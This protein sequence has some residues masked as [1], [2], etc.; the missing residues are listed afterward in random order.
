M[1]TKTIAILTKQEDSP[2]ELLKVLAG[3]KLQLLVVSSN[4][5]RNL[6]LIKQFE[7]LDSE[8]ELDFISCEK[9]GCWEAD[10]IILYQV[11]EFPSAIIERIREVATQKTVLVVSQGHAQSEGLDFKELLPHSRVIAVALAELQEGNINSYFEYGEQSITEA[12]RQ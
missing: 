8:A 1:L 5:E 12:S 10:V 11:A 6:R 2:L 3:Q 7:Q 9:E 4:Q